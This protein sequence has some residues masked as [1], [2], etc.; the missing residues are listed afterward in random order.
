MKKN[1]SNIIREGVTYLT[2]VMLMMDVIR[3]ESNKKP[4]F[5]RVEY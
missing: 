1:K 3:N 2:N 4:R 5:I